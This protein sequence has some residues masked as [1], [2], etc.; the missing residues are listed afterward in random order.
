M[1]YNDPIYTNVQY[2]T[3]K[4]LQALNDGDLQLLEDLLED[5]T[6]DETS[7]DNL[8]DIDAT[9]EDDSQSTMLHVAADLGNAEAVRVLILHLLSVY[10]L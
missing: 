1:T 5:A 10:Q 7:N 3:K 9:G 6:S 8:V 2:I 4:A